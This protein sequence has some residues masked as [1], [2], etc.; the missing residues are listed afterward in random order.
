MNGRRL[1]EYKVVILVAVWFKL[2]NGE[3]DISCSVVSGP[4]RPANIL[5]KDP[6]ITVRK[7]VSGIPTQSVTREG[8]I[9]LNLCFKTKQ[10]FEF[11]VYWAE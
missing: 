2:H 5:T 9:R 11:D 7:G 1:L 3:A 4:E 6:I 8:V 10:V